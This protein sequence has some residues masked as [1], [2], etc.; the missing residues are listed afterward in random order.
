VYLA[1]VA[2]GLTTKTDKLGYVYA[3]PIPQ[4]IANID[5]FE[6]GARSVNPDAKTYTV[7]TSSWCDPAKQALAAQNLLSQGVDVISQHQDCTA[8]VIKTTE[9][10]GAY[11]VGYHADASAL[12]PKGWLTGSEWNWGPLYI[13]IVK[14]ALAGNFPGSKYNANYRV[15]FKT[16]DNPFVQSKFGPAV[17]PDTQAAVAKAKADISKP[18]GSPFVGPVRDQG[19]TVR[20]PEGQ[21]PDYAT[22]DVI[23]YFVEGVVGQLPKS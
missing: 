22:L 5:A 8:T 10:A 21:V 16:G 11:T 18:D 7:N 19:G 13:D 6:L 17:T 1:G 9:A 2:A 20:I 12:A 4:T 3:F 14:T 15:G 23:N